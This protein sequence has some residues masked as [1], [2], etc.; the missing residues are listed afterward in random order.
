[1]ANM[2]DEEQMSFLGELLGDAPAD[3]AVDTE[4]DKTEDINLQSDDVK[5]EEDQK[6]ITGDDIKVEGDTKVEEPIQD[7]EPE[8]D[9]NAILREQ[10]IKLTEQLQKDPTQQSVQPDIGEGDKKDIEQK[11]EALKAF[12][13]D[14]EIDRIID[15]PQ[16]L[17]TA[18]NRALNVMQQ[19][20]QSVI[21]SEVNRQVMVSRAVSDFYT[22]N[23]DLAPY[24]K[25]VQFVMSEVESQNPQKTYAEI[26]QM[27]AAETRKRL[28]FGVPQAPRQQQQS[29]Q[30]GQKAKPA[31]AGSKHGTQRPAG[32]QEFFDPNAADM[33]NLL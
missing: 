33:F 32:K 28:G 29:P 31:F 23:Q 6:V 2:M 27:T 22:S 8:Q 26:F 18:F 14:D 24:G 5:T 30:S 19:N 20:M 11:Q 13:S 15:E 1:M 10:I 21:Q 7:G 16:L 12:L 25:F 4:Q 17:N 3:D 9:V